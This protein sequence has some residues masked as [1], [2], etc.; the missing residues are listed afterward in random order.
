M[1][2][3]EVEG[4]LYGC[5]FVAIGANN[6]R[7]TLLLHFLSVYFF[8]VMAIWEFSLPCSACCRCIVLLLSLSIDPW[9]E[10]LS[11]LDVF[12]G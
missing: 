6:R 12:H 8:S 7:T 2:S 5:G 11:I 10:S 3:R 4:T 9:D 1:Q